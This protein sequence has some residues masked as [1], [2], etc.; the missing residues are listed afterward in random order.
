MSKAPFIINARKGFTYGDQ[1]MH[2]VIAH[3]GLT[4]ANN[5]MSMG[6][7]AEKTAADFKITR[8]E[9]DAYCKQ[10]YQRHIEAAKNGIFAE[11]IVGVKIKEKGREEEIFAEDEEGKR[12]REEK[13]ASIPS[14]FMREGTI[15]AANASK[16]NDGACSVGTSSLM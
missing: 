11:E 7:C 16:I 12:Y 4:D 2:D 1:K 10:S 15:T 5:K 14:A 8:E 13:I 3:D 9:Q 6:L